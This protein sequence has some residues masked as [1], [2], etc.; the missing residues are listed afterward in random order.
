MQWNNIVKDVWLEGI[1]R[2]VIKNH[3]SILWDES[4]I[5]ALLFCNLRKRMRE[6]Y[7]KKFLLVPEYPLNIPKNA[8]KCK[9]QEHK[10]VVEKLSERVEG[11]L[12]PTERR[13]VDLCIVE[14]QRDLSYLDSE[15]GGNEGC[16]KNDNCTL[17]CFE[18]TPLVAFE[19]KFTWQREILRS[20]SEDI[21][22]LNDM[23]EVWGTKIAVLCLI[24]DLCNPDEYSQFLNQ[25]KAKVENN[26]ERFRIALGSWSKEELWSVE[27]VL[28]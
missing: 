18:P 17:W 14:F 10:S 23:I 15:K 16:N 11:L 6:D 24:T 12:D 28:K 25:L 20:I 13:K 3:N 22:K 19:I 2:D 4:G 9:K 27:K 1:K 26:N 8:R 21:K 7:G 5:Q